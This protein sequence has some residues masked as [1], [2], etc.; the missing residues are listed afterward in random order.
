MVCLTS[1]AGFFVGE[2]RMRAKMKYQVILC[3]L[4]GMVGENVTRTQ[5]FSDLQQGEQKGHK[6]NHLLNIFR[7]WFRLSTKLH[8]SETNKNT[9]NKKPM[10]NG[11]K[12]KHVPPWKSMVGRCIPYLN[13]P[14]FRDM[15][16][17]G[18]VFF[19]FLDIKLAY[20]QEPRCSDSADW[21]PLQI[22]VWTW[23]LMLVTSNFGGYR[24]GHVA[25]MTWVVS[26]L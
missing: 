5:R 7:S 22:K 11:D 4:F 17:F 19:S 14:F 21:W 1:R 23:C 12:E 10:K 3:D 16:V 26:F 13:S 25:W 15:L 6:L 24:F 20:F 8:S 18:G 2:R 9:C